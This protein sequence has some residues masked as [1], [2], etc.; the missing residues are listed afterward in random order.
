MYN[1]TLKMVDNVP[2]LYDIDENDV[3][4]DIDDVNINDQ[5][6]GNFY[7]EFTDYDLS[8]LFKIFIYK[9]VGL[10]FDVSALDGGG[11]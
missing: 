10:E 6:S 11:K 5:G 1:L 4:D 9:N 3:T 8:I 2:R 7:V